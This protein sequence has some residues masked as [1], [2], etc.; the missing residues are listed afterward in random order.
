LFDYQKTSTAIPKSPIRETRPPWL[1]S[2]SFMFNILTNY[3]T[4]APVPKH[5]ISAVPTGLITAV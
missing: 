1:T 5:S 2:T 3:Q 4:T